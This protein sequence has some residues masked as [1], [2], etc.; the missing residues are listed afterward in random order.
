MSVSV[1]APS[2][3]VERTYAKVT[4]RILSVVAICYLVSYVD[5]VKVS[6]AKL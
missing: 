5:R 6:F 3:F 4:S 2:S 1:D